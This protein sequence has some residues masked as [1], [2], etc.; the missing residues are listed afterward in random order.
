MEAAVA[1]TSDFSSHLLNALP[2]SFPVAGQRASALTPSG[3]LVPVGDGWWR[4][5]G[6]AGFVDAALAAWSL[7]RRSQVGTPE[8]AVALAQAQWR[9]HRPTL[10]GELFV[11]ECFVRQ[12]KEDHAWAVVGAALAGLIVI[13][14]DDPDQSERSVQ[15]AEADRADYVGGSDFDAEV[16]ATMARIATS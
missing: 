2:A 3:A 16:Q 10:F 7:V 14:R 6:F 13:T 8:E 1:A 5:V 4:K 12:K 11:L 15:R 9:Q